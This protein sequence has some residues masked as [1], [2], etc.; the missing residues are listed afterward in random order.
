[1]RKLLIVDDD[2]KFAASLVRSLSRREFNCFIAHDS[3]SALEICDE[4]APQFV[5]LDLNLEGESGQD[6]VAPIKVR[7]PHAQIVILTGHGSI[8]STV[9]A[10]REGAVSYLCKPASPDEIE[11]ALMTKNPDY[12]KELKDVE[13]EHIRRV[14]NDCGGNISHAAEK[15]GLHRR[16]LQRKLKSG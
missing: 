2:S 13:E 16:T 3:Q 11:Q 14:L 9:Q 7:V 12:D 1:M 15:L 6:L 4:E 10:M 5:I 8:P